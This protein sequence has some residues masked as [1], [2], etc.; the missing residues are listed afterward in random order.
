MAGEEWPAAAL[1]AAHR[2]VAVH[3]LLVSISQTAE[4]QILESCWIIARDV[5]DV[6][7]FAAAR[8]PML[9]GDEVRRRAAVWEQAR[10]NRD[11]RGLASSRPSEALR[12]VSDL[13]AEGVEAGGLPEIAEIVALPPRRR[14]ARIRE[15]LDAEGRN[16]AGPEPEREAE[17]DEAEPPRPSPAKL[18]E[19]AAR[20]LG[21][22]ADAVEAFRPSAASARRLLRRADA[23][24]ARLE[25]LLEALTEAAA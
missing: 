24:G 3:D 4:A 22:A 21:E 12:L 25:D 23:A 13:A 8:L 15:L 10:R 2:I 17:H 11:L 1:R 20:L 6:D 9:S 18:L 14:H 5:E 19:E 16:G 7:A